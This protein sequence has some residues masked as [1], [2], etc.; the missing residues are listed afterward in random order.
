MSDSLW[1]HGPQYARLPYLHHL[2]ELAQTHVHW[3][4]DTIQPAQTNVHWVEDT[5][6]PSCPLPL[7]LL[8]SIFPSLLQWIISLCQ[9]AKV[10]ELQL[11][12]QSF[13]L[14]FGVDSLQDWLVWSLCSPRDSQESSPTSQ[15]KNINFLM[16]SFLYIPTVTFVHDNW[17][18]HIL[19]SMDIYWQSN[20]SAFYMLSRFVIVFLLRSKCLL[21]SWLQSPSI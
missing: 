5:I 8:P 14:I 1:P 17:K 7:L 6:Q 13:Q 20:V 15:F 21:I 2:L 11:Q 18:N 16:L 12:H 19:D 4:S 10:L 3:V 9:M